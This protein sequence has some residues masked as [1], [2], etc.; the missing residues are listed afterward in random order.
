MIAKRGN[1]LWV[2]K[3]TGRVVNTMIMAFD[4]AKGPKKSCIACCATVNENFSLY[5]S[6]SSTYSNNEDKFSEMVKLSFEAIN[7]Y[8]K[9][10][11]KTP[12]EVLIF[13]NSCTGDQ[14]ALFTNFFLTGLTNKLNE[15]FTIGIPHLSLIMVNTKTS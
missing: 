1:V 9:K 13:H 14:V 5:Y 6:K 4:T 7:F 11:M 12:K 2:P 8:V 15:S 3:A 10:N